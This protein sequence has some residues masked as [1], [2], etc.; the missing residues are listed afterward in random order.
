MGQGHLSGADAGQDTRGGSSAS[1]MSPL[2]PAPIP[3]VD[4]G[5]ESDDDAEDEL[6]AD[7]G[8]SPRP[9]QKFKRVRPER[10]GWTGMFSGLYGDWWALPPT[11]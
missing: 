8:S 1:A 2:R 6:H 4:E 3:E 11:P 9:P 10:I 7:L 5:Q